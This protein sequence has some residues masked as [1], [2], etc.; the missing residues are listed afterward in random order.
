[1]IV[2]LFDA[3]TACRALIPRL[4]AVVVL[5]ALLLAPSATGRLFERAVEHEAVSISAE[6]RS[7]LAPT[8]E[9]LA[10]SRAGSSGSRA[11]GHD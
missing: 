1:V 7:A 10:A 11:R 4:T 8:L 2:D 5:G 3:L 9:R 6:L